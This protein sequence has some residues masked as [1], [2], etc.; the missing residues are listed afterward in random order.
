MLTDMKAEHVNIISILGFF[1][2]N[3]IY[4]YMLNGLQIIEI[5]EYTY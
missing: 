4:M 1:H 2:L 3:N 5:H